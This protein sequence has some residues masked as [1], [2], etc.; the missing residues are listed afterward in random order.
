MSGLVR[1]FVG[2]LRPPEGNADRLDAWIAST[3]AADLLHLHAFI[4]DLDQNR[5]AVCAAVTLPFSN[6]D[7]EGVHTKI[8]RIMRQM[9]YRV[10]FVGLRHCIVLA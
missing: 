8:K 10:G 1:G 2:L 7:S 5:D 4:L 9:H 6:G 3:K